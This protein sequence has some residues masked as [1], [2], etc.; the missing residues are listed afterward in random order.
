MSESKLCVNCK[1]YRTARGGHAVCDA[2]PNL[3][4]GQPTTECSTLRGDVDRCG[5]EG[6]AFEQIEP[7]DKEDK[8]TFLFLGAVILLILAVIVWAVGP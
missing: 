2:F 8:Q 4:N 6:K 5:K 1:H 3:V 7:L